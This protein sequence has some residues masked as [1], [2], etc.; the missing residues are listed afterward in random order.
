MLMA[1]TRARVMGID[2][3]L[4]KRI[5]IALTYIFGIGRKFSNEILKETKINPDI[6]VKDIN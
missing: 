3:P 1:L 5:E 2:I 6:L 4:E